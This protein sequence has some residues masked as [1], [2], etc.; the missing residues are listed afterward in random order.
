M[1]WSIF[2]SPCPK[3]VHTV[4]EFCGFFIF[5]RSVLMEFGIFMAVNSH[6][7]QSKVN[8]QKSQEENSSKLSNIKQ[9]LAIAISIYKTTAVEYKCMHIRFITGCIVVDFCNKQKNVFWIVIKKANIFF[10]TKIQKVFIFFKKQLRHVEINGIHN[11]GFL[12]RLMIF[13]KNE[14]FI[15]QFSLS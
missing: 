3:C 5:K 2:C 1:S 7:E 15:P 10:G 8:L 9:Y 4:V 6:G 13:W 12:K 11:W 14:V